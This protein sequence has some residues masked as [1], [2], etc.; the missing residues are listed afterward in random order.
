KMS[1][2]LTGVTKR[3]LTPEEKTRV[4]AIISER[5]RAMWG[6]EAKRAEIVEAIIRA[7]AS[8]EVRARVS[9]GVRRKWQEPEYR[10]QYSEEHFSRMAHVLW[11]DPA[12]RE[13]HREKIVRQRED[14]AFCEAQ[15]R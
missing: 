7:M 4:A 5:S 2:V 14:E 15:R 13:R 11:E 10:A 3:A 12:A 9:A 1:A 8:A 6:N